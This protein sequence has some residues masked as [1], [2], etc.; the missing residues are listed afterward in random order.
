MT[1]KSLIPRVN[2]F[3]LIRLVAAL[4]VVFMHG[5]FHLK[6]NNE[7][8]KNF[9]EKFIQYFPGVPIFFTVSGFLIFWAFDRNPNLNKYVTNRILRLYPALY[10][11]LLITILLL[12]LFSTR[13]LVNQTSFYIWLAAQMSFFQFY[14]PEILRFW[15]VGT[16]NGSLWTIAV[17]VQFY[18][19]VP[20]IYFLMK[21]V[22]GSYVLFFF[23][24]TSVCANIY[25]SNINIGTLSKLS[26][27]S[28]LPYLFNFLVGSFF[29]FYWNKLK[30]II[31][32]KFLVWIS[33]YIIYFNIFGN[34]LGYQINS[35]HIVNVFNFISV[36]FLSITTL[37]FAFSFNSLS[38]RLLKRQDISYGIYIY[39]MLV[40][41][42]LVTLGLQ[43]SL[44]SFISVF[45]ITILLSLLSWNFL[46]K[47][48]LS[49]KSKK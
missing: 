49:L 8:L 37:S 18:I 29:Y 12:F 21:R 13:S 24:L 44:F 39:H 43:G 28:I 20:I 48:A 17:E 46:E 35:Y 31:E 40:V 7:F 5:F 19:L 30:I 22:K 1:E 41:N 4:Q 45:T 15:G 2:N 36:I 27:V 26:G 9:F 32:N 42:T 14:T 23:F 33:A 10:I 11:C 6:I 38:E 3:D 25:F 16:P 47:K 34:F